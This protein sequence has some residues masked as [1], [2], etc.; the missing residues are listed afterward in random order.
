MREHI[1]SGRLLYGGGYLSLGVMAEGSGR[2]R[3]D[4]ETA[5]GICFF[6]CFE[7]VLGKVSIDDI[8]SSGAP[9]RT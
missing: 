5:T 6:Q 8:P 7:M 1:D 4:E 3:D 2:V 9:Q